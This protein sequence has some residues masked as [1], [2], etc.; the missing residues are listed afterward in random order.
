MALPHSPFLNPKVSTPM[1][2]INPMIVN[3]YILKGKLVHRQRRLQKRYRR[4]V[5]SIR[6]ELGGDLYLPSCLKALASHPLQAKY[7]SLS[8]LLGLSYQMC[9]V[10]PIQPKQSPTTL[11][12]CV[13]FHGP[14]AK[15]NVL[16]CL[17]SRFRISTTPKASWQR[18]PS[19]SK[20]H[21]PSNKHEPA[22]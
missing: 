18:P 6:E 22:R 5:M 14:L 10:C 1:I 8:T 12:H 2:S 16:S 21:A 4:V 19:P 9:L 17:L 11:R 15:T 13:S 3:V 7:V 20:A